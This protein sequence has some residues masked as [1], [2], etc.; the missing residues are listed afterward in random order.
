MKK[1]IDNL[2]LLNTFCCLVLSSAIFAQESLVLLKKLDK[3][4]PASGLN[5]SYIG[6]IISYIGDVNNDDFDDWAVGLPNAVN[7][8]TGETVGKVYIY[9]GGNPIQN[10]KK[11]DI[12]LSGD[13][14]VYNFGYNIT[15][16]GDVNN[17][18]FSDIIMYGNKQTA[19]YFGGNPMDTIPDVIFSKGNSTGYFGNSFSCAGDVNNDGFD[20]VIIGQRNNAYIY[21]GGTNMDSKADITLTEGVERDWFGFTV[22]KAGDINNDGFDDVIVGA[23]GY[24]SG[25]YDA[26]RVYVYFGDVNMDTIPDM[27]MT[28]EHAGD[29][30]GSTVANAGDLNNEGFDDV[31]VSAY[32]Y[33]NK[34]KEPG[35]VYIYY[36]GNLKDTIADIIIDGSNGQSGGDI[37]KDGFSD[38]IINY[39]VYWGGSS[40]DNIADYTLANAPRIAG[41]GDY[42]NDGYAD[43]ITGQPDDDTNGESAGSVSIFFGGSQLNSSPD[44]VFYGEPSFDYFGLSVSSAGD[45]NNDGYNDFIIGS[46]GNDQVALNAGCAY[47]YFGGETLQN[48]PDLTHTGQKTNGRFGSSVSCADDVNGDGFSDILVGGFSTG[49]VKLY[50]GNKVMDNVADLI[51]KGGVSSSSF[52][53]SVSSA[54]DFNNDGFSDIMVGA[55][56]YDRNNLLSRLYIYYGNYSPCRIDW[57]NSGGSL[58]GRNHSIVTILALPQQ[59]QR[60]GLYPS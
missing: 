34:D 8:E 46:P 40:M 28:G 4:L 38:L 13:S 22:S 54:G 15:C 59:G 7:Y 58:P 47:V 36:G 9:F 43:V 20:D 23:L 29:C 37:N 3:G 60:S 19:L 44:V 2:K 48:K 39:S 45:L 51:L 18:G 14:G 27:I 12:I 53:N 25:G 17:D 16:A 32:H 26:G 42:N 49:E 33:E 50:F 57:K 41:M 56:R 11:P 10:N 35:R 6:E 24:S 5:G 21:F 1:L 55:P 30:F 52:G 31:L